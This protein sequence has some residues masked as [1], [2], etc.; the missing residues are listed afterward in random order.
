[1]TIIGKGLRIDT[2]STNAF[3]NVGCTQATFDFFDND[4]KDRHSSIICPDGPGPGVYYS[5]GGPAGWYQH[6][7]EVC[8]YWLKIDGYPCAEIRQ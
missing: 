6:G 7:T 5:A 1:M 2:W 3:G 8:N 4:Y